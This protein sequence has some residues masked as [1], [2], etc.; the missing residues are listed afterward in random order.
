M[1]FTVES[2]GYFEIY[3]SCK[4]DITSTDVGEN[5]TYTIEVTECQEDTLGGVGRAVLKNGEIVP[6]EEYLTVNVNEYVSLVENATT[7]SFSRS[8]MMKEDAEFKFLY[9]DLMVL[10]D[11]ENDRPWYLWSYSLI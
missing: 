4:L 6:W 1:R 9:F 3:P 5:T 8:E 7:V 11:E 2:P 10:P